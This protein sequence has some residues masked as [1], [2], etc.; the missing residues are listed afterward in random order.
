M[1]T[2]DRI[3]KRK[4]KELSALKDQNRNIREMFK[5]MKSREQSNESAELPGGSSGDNIATANDVNPTGEP[6]ITS[7]VEENE[8]SE[9]TT[10][11]KRKR[12]EEAAE[13]K[14][15]KWQTLYPSLKCFEVKQHDSDP[16][17]SVAYCKSC[18][19]QAQL[20]LSILKKHS[21]SKLY[22]ARASNQAGSMIEKMKR[23]VIERVCVIIHAV[24]VA[25]VVGA[26]QRATHHLL[27]SFQ[28]YGACV[29]SSWMSYGYSWEFVVA[30]ARIVT[31]KLVNGV[32]ASAAHHINYDLST[33]IATKKRLAVIFTYF[34]STVGR[35]KQNL[36][37][38]MGTIGNGL[39]TKK[40]I[41]DLYNTAGINPDKCVGACTDGGGPEKKAF[42]LLVQDSFFHADAQWSHCLVHRIAL[43]VE[44]AWSGSEFCKRVESLFISIYNPVAVTSAKGMQV[45]A[46]SSVAVQEYVIKCRNLRSRGDSLEVKDLAELAAQSG[47]E[48]LIYR[49]ISGLIRAPTSCGAER[50]FSVL[51]RELSKSQ[52]RLD[53]DHLQSDT[54]LCANRD[55]LLELIAPDRTG[56]VEV[57]H[58][59]MSMKD[60]REK[61]CKSS[62]DLKQASPID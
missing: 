9:I 35:V 50:S 8:H 42:E 58:E 19:A 37:G 55:L 59:W 2:S 57:A 28:H 12:D 22:L 60:R 5:A 49:V 62:E 7:D 61:I 1:P 27:A 17:A 10:N 29:S 14:L 31:K 13:A 46:D 54:I 45:G 47:N 11:R 39:E 38:F 24:L 53:N 3:R 41:M 20:K 40:K 52:N 26:A 34:D 23:P 15:L 56:L 18:R 33:D 51:T 48:D 21:E 36:I 32:N 16:T 30:A 43:A 6:P 44:D 25:M 4:E